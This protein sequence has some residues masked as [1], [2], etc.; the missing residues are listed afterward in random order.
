MILLWT[1]DSIVCVF[2][3]LYLLRCLISASLRLQS[4]ESRNSVYW[5]IPSTWH[6]DTKKCRY[7]DWVDVLGEW[8]VIS[9][10]GNFKSL[11]VYYLWSSSKSFFLMTQVYFSLGLMTC[12]KIGF[13]CPYFSQFSIAVSE[14][15]GS[16]MRGVLPN[17]L[18]SVDGGAPSCTLTWNQETHLAELSHFACHGKQKTGKIQHFFPCKLV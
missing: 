10:L 16:R 15:R 6:M 17:G 5:Y 4:L 2:L 12:I 14:E 18:T 9:P 3:T 1:C 7:W 8:G 11:N 13:S